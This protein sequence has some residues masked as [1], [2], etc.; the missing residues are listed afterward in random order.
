MSTDLDKEIAELEAKLQEAKKKKTL[1]PKIV[2]IY[3]FNRNTGKVYVK[4]SDVHYGVV[5]ILRRT[6]G[7]IYIAGDNDNSI[8]AKQIPSFIQAIESLPK[9]TNPVELTWHPSTKDAFDKFMA[10]PDMYLSLL[11]EKSLVRIELGPD[12]ID[13]RLYLSGDIQ[14]LTFKPE[15]NSY[16]LGL[17]EVWKFPKAIQGYYK[18]KK[19]EYQPELIEII[20]EQLKKQEEMATIATAMDWPEVKNPFIDGYDLKPLQRVAVKFSEMTEDKCV[21]AYPMGKGKTAIAAAI[22][23]LR[24]Y[25]KTLVICPAP[26]KTNWVREIKKFTGKDAFILYGATPSEEIIDEL[27]RHQGHQFYIINYDIMARATVEDKEQDISVN[28]W[29][30]VLQLARFDLMVIDEAHRIKNTDSK[31]SRAVTALNSIP[32][33]ISLTGTP[34]VNRPSE[35]YPL[36]FLADPKSFANETSFSNQFMYADGSPKNTSQLKQ[37]LTRYMIRRTPEQ[38]GEHEV[39]RIPFHKELSPQAR[40]NYKKILE[41]VYISLRNPNYQRDITSIL[42]ELTRCKQTCANDNVETSADL[43]LEALEETDKKVL[44]FSQFKEP[45][46]TIRNIIGNSAAIINGEVSNDRRYELIDQFQ[47]PKSSL[48]VIITNIT[49]A[50]TLTEAHTVIFNDLWWTPK[51]HS[52]AEGRAFNRTNDPHGGN[53]YWVQND[54]TIDDFL[55]DLL[56]KKMAI[57]K[58]VIDGVVSEGESQGSLAMEL[59]N[60]LRQGL[61]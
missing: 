35:L 28:K 5:E 30:M 45:Q 23:E 42:A 37:L 31:R 60:H 34:I 1:Q 4:L 12:M 21:V 25:K 56:H 8:P 55:I 40:E 17:P 27:I 32:H 20:N 59:I 43:A 36:L 18:N 13:Q 33:I 24:Q 3:R 26:A 61:G 51:D 47:D 7:R 15:T 52:Q 38:F 44:V 2:N 6:P 29:S 41:G 50:L 46:A 54:R 19:I 39:T 57:F 11:D 48:K 14:S 9:D 53:S 58:E 16:T 49:E 10:M 22:H